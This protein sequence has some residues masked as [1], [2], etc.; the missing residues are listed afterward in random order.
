MAPAAPSTSAATSGPSGGAIRQRAANQQ[1]STAPSSSSLSKRSRR[2]TRIAVLGSGLTGLSAAHALATSS[3]SSDIDLHL[4]ER[5]S[6]VGLDS[7]SIDVGPSP[8]DSEG[9]HKGMSRR[10]DVPMRSINEGYYPNVVALYRRLGVPLRK[11]DFTYSFTELAREV[12]ASQSKAS[13]S[14]VPSPS[15][16]YE[17]SSGLRGLSVPSSL[18]REWHRPQP[19]GNPLRKAVRLTLDYGSY[20]ADAA[21]LFLGYLYLVIVALYHHYSGHTRDPRHP[22]ATQSLEEY[23][24]PSDTNIMG[25]FVQRLLVPLFSAMMTVQA[26]SVLSSPVAEVLDYV[27]LTFGR[28]HL[29]VAT[30]VSQVE[31]KIAEPLQDD[32]IHIDC[33]VAGLRREESGRITVTVENGD[34]ET[35]DHLGFDHVILAT[36]ANQSAVFVESFLQTLPTPNER[37][38]ELADQLRRFKYEDSQVVNHSDVSLLPTD[39]ADWRD[40]SLIT[41]TS[42]DLDNSA[43]STPSSSPSTPVEAELVRGEGIAGSPVHPKST[44]VANTHTMA[45]HLLDR[46]DRHNVLVQTTNPLAELYPRPETVLSVSHF[47]RAVLTLEGKAA[48]RGLFEWKQKRT[49]AS[50]SSSAS[51]PLRSIQPWLWRDQWELQLGALQGH[52]GIW[53]CGSWSPGIPLLEGCVTSSQLVVRELLRRIDGDDEDL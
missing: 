14:R 8:A 3:R 37:L 24:C 32:K 2:P 1:K 5:A 45:C 19:S 30:G 53:T 13:P 25:C 46:R 44:L 21:V 35:E 27:A 41:P 28:S 11:S 47:E 51:S 22:I 23:L 33:R 12:T 26:S 16:I 38:R 43:I 48:Q 31:Q 50:S 7:N 49:A 52:G 40:L 17:G 42:Q 36:Q 9:R 20:V 15:F 6:K 29:T 10:I 34:G 18:R 4:F 39:P